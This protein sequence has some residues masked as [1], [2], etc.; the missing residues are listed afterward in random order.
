MRVSTSQLNRL[1]LN[2][3]LEQQAKASRSQLEISS[4]KK[5]LTPSD[6]PVGTVKSLSM[7]R[8]LERLSQFERNGSLL[9]GRLAQQESLMT[10]GV[11]ILQRVREIVVQGA[12]G[13]Q[14]DESRQL[15]AIEV[16]QQLQSMLQVANTQDSEGRFIFS[17]MDESTPAVPTTPP[18]NFNGSTNVR[19]LQ[20]GPSTFIKDTVDG[21]KAFGFD[22]AQNVFDLLSSIAT[23]L[24][25]PSASS[26]NISAKLS[27]LDKALG[28]LSVART[29]IGVR[30]TQIDDQVAL[31]SGVVLQLQTA[32]SETKDVDYAEAITRFNQQLLGLQAAQQAYS[33]VQG[34][35]LFN[36]L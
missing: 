13:T 20:I 33:K 18:F 36:Y 7:Q 21:F 17:G 28:A 16:R 22:G 5:I 25:T 14:G 6:D 30:L 35:S 34:L 23:E 8:N 2:S 4:G 9:Q 19:D 31:S 11:N 32:L 3:I 1:A 24:E 27:D 12:N 15:L 29:E 10:N 26:T